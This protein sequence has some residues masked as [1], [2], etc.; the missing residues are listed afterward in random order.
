MSLVE[1]PLRAAA[2][3][4][5]PLVE[6]PVNLEKSW[7]WKE[8]VEVDTAICG[9]TRALNKKLSHKR[10][11]LFLD[12]YSFRESGEEIC[13]FP[14]SSGSGSLR[15]GFTLPRGKSVFIFY[16]SA[17]ECITSSALPNSVYRNTKYAHR[18]AR[19]LPNADKETL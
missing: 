12:T 18:P 16:S 4:D 15:C 17:Q 2:D 13:R 8:D 5:A 1:T 19:Y 3:T 10:K 11:L 7:W 9:S 14:V 6:C